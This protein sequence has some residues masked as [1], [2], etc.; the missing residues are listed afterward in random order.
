[1]KNIVDFIQRDLTRNLYV[2]YIVIITESTNEDQ[3][4]MHMGFDDI[5]PHVSRKD[6]PF[7]CVVPVLSPCILFYDLFGEDITEDVR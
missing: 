5:D 1:M 4:A 7:T 6:W 3:P 2:H